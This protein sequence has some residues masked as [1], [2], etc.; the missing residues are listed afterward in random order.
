MDPVRALADYPGYG[1]SVDGRIWSKRQSASGEWKPMHQWSDA[2]GYSRTTIRV[3]GKRIALYVHRAVVAA[4]VGPVPKGMTV[5]HMDGRK[6]NNRVENLEVV[7]HLE[8]MRH[9]YRLGLIQPIT[10][11]LRNSLGAKRAPKE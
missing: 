2:G 10:H 8:N 9:G 1:V 7:T 4:F 3:G 5:N 6:P 11:H